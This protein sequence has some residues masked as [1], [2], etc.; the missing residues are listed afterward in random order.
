MSATAT[1]IPT[2][3]LRKFW[4]ASVPICD[5]YDMV[6]S[7]EYDCQFV[8]V[9]NETIV[10]HDRACGRSGKCCG[11]KGRCPCS[12]RRTYPTSS[13]TPVNTMTDAP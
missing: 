6:D 4:R 12:R 9:T 1:A 11:L 13:T 5:R 10:F 7:P 3:A 2:E 8:L